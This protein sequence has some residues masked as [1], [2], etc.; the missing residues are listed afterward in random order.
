MSYSESSFAGPTLFGP[1]NP[2]PTHFAHIAAWQERNRLARIHDNCKR[3][4]RN[5]KRSRY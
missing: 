3:L 5:Y 1:S 4:A 2:S